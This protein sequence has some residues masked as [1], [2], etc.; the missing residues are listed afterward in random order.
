MPR[1]SA[2]KENYPSN[3][4][5]PWK[6]ILHPCMILT[7]SVVISLAVSTC[8]CIIVR[9]GHMIACIYV[10]V[11]WIYFVFVQWLD[12]DWPMRVRMRKVTLGNLVLAV[13]VSL[14]ILSLYSMWSL[15]PSI[16]S[17]FY[18]SNCVQNAGWLWP[19]LD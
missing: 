6:K 10:H 16:S 11:N 18:P 17:R 19:F 9:K 5:P 13:I 2:G 12:K 4:L 1:I 7:P 3:P 15:P 14:A 8:M